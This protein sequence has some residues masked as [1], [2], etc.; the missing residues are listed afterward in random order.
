MDVDVEDAGELYAGFNPFLFAH[1]CN[2]KDTH[3]YKSFPSFAE[4]VDEYFSKFEQ[5]KA[6][7]ELD[8]AR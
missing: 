6:S 3:L 8:K 4:A 2:E 1:L 5:Q 7:R